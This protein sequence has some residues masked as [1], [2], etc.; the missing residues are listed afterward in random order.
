MLKRAD[1]PRRSKQAPGSSNWNANVPPAALVG[2]GAADNVGAGVAPGEA[3]QG[4]EGEGVGRCAKG[5]EREG[6]Q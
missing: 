3:N 5:V 1:S 4:D 6:A 2:G